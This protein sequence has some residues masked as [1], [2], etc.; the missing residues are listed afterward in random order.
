MLYSHVPRHKRN[1]LKTEAK[2][3]KD[4]VFRKREIKTKEPINKAT[5]TKVGEKKTSECSLD[6]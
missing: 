2:E 6:G 5:R 3:R 1:I 4:T